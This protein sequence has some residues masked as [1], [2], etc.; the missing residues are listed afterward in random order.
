MA[1]GEE[2]VTFVIVINVLISIVCFYIAWRVVKLRRRIA[3]FADKIIVAE[4]R[5]YA[6]LHK[7]PPGI[8]KGQWGTQYLQERY[9]QLEDRLQQLRQVLVLLTLGQKIWQGRSKAQIGR[10][11]QMQKG[12]G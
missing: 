4:R 2:M 5:T 3:K 11:T 1:K 12:R 7:A 9:R 10:R 6:V 8:L